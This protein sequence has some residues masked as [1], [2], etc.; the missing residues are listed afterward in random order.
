MA[1]TK[2]TKK[3]FDE[4]IANWG[5]TNH[6]E[7]VNRFNKFA[8]SYCKDNNNTLTKDEFVKMVKKHTYTSVKIN[9]GIAQRYYYRLEAI[10]S[11]CT[12]NKLY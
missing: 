6:P 12:S 10:Q 7:D 1:L 8:L 9:R 4:W 2:K 5:A 11:F 3:S